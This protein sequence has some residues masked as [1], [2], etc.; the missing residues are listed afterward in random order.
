[1]RPRDLHARVTIEL[2]FHL[3]LPSRM[4]FLK[5]PTSSAALPF[6]V[7]TKASWVLGF[8]RNPSAPLVL[9]QPRHYGVATTS[10][11]DTTRIAEW[12]KDT[13]LDRAVML[14]AG[15][16][17]DLRIWFA[18]EHFPT[19]AV[20]WADADETRRLIVFLINNFLSRYQAASGFTPAAGHVGPISEMDLRHFSVRLFDGDSPCSKGYCIVPALPAQPKSESP[21]FPP[22]ALERFEAA[23]R[24]PAVSL[25]LELAH[26]AHSLLYRGRHEQSI[27]GWMQALE[28]AV[29]QIAGHLR[30]QLPDRGTVE[31]HLEVVLNTQQMGPLEEALRIGLIEARRL[32]VVTHFES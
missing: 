6:I 20:A 31:E 2:P 12:V 18:E 8:A 28:V 26:D 14:P 17:L 29:D 7:K 3:A 1:M 24:I 13:G 15:T 21:E 32:R 11:S 25:W 23:L 9:Q 27:V 30:V 16:I 10:E 5:Q 19:D 4:Y 22:N